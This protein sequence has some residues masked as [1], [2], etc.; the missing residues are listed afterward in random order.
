MDATSRNIPVPPDLLS[1]AQIIIDADLPSEHN[2]PLNDVDARSAPAHD[3]QERVSHPKPTRSV[4]GLSS[5]TCAWEYSMTGFAEQ[6]VQK[7]C[8]LANTSVERLRSVKTPG[9]DESSFPPDMF[10]KKGTLAP[11][12]AQ[13]VLKYLWLARNYRYD[14]YYV[15]NYLARYVTKWTAVCDAMLYQLT[16]YVY[17]TQDFVQQC[18]IG[19]KAQD[20]HI[21][22]FVDASHVPDTSSSVST[23]GA[24]LVLYGPQTFVPITAIC[25]RQKRTAHSS[26]ESEMIILEEAL[27][28]EGIP[29]MSLWDCVLHVFD[30]VVS[31]KDTSSTSYCT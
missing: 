26:T 6:C 3:T 18:A 28:S 21:G 7:Y 9:L 15:V 1:S 24:L 22:L 30:P 5:S 29:Y 27:R 31:E 13:I 2:I 17:S 23:G 14:I 19:N 8:D 20:I 12:A 16:C 25:K 10:E 4:P 11:V